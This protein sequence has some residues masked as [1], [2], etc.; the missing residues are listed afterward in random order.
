MKVFA[1]TKLGRRVA[2]THE[3]SDDEMRVLHYLRDNK[4]ATDD[5][6][7][8]ACGGRWALRKLKS[9]GLIIELTS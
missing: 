7:E 5:E 3:G 8:V 9:R 1:L 2:S 6:I 4:T